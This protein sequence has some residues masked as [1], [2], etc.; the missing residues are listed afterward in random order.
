MLRIPYLKLIA[1]LLMLIVSFTAGAAP[2]TGT[3]HKLDKR[4]AIIAAAAQQNRSRP[5]MA[6]ALTRE[7]FQQNSPL[8][9]RWNAAGQVQVYLRYAHHGNVPDHGELAALGASGMVDS[10]EL[11][12][13]Q[14]WIPAD[15]LADAAALSGVTRISIPHYAFTRR[16][17]PS[18]ALSR[19]G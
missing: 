15:R 3:G 12:V 11:N 18:V 6:F 10:P 2:S 1:P 9:A 16:A 14:A 7:L 5:L 17:P 19:T 4:L 13:V 8:E